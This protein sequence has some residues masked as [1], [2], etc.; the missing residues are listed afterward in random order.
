ML[1]QSSVSS[2]SRKEKRDR[3]DDG[4]SVTTKRC[5]NM[6]NIPIFVRGAEKLA[7]HE[8]HLTSYNFC[9]ESI[10][11]IADVMSSAIFICLSLYIYVIRAFKREKHKKEISCRSTA[12][13]ANIRHYEKC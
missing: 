5:K 6:R 12:N 9:V 3:N 10:R 13:K 11:T 7:T 2:P 4:I 8:L 1:F